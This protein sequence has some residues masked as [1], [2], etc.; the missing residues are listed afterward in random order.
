MATP[1][2]TPEEFEAGLKR[3]VE[4]WLDTTREKREQKLAGNLEQMWRDYFEMTLEEKIERELEKTRA[5]REE[6][7]AEQMTRQWR[8]EE[9]ES[10]R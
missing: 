7:L 9:V 10:K 3:R 4:Q 2:P 6:Q 8:R 5:E 1:K